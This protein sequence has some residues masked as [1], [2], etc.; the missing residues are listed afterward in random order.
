LVGS[1][2]TLNNE[3]PVKRCALIVLVDPFDFHPAVLPHGEGVG[4]NVTANEVKSAKTTCTSISVI[5]GSASVG[6]SGVAN[7][8]AT[9]ACP[10]PTPSIKPFRS[11]CISVP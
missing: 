8:A 6:A 9:L 2:R 10:T 3:A 11:R 5:T 7:T 4:C 1:T